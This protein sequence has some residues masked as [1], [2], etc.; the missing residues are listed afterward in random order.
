MIP[1]PGDLLL[2]HRRR[3]ARS[4][5]AGPI[6]ALISWSIQRTTRSR[7]NHVAIADDDRWR[8]GAP[9]DATVPGPIIEAE[10]TGVRRGSMFA[11]GG[12]AHDVRVLP[13]PPS[14]DRDAVVAFARS[15][16][17]AKYDRR[18]ILAMQFAA[19]AWGTRGI[20]RI[21]QARDRAWICSELAAAA[22]RAG[23][24][25]GEAFDPGDF[26]RNP[27]SLAASIHPP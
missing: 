1:R 2:I 15:Q 18:L 5:L 21:V 16:L 11:Y 12:G 13:C 20:R 7:W 25:V 4:L 24:W 22:W 9:S 8:P 23:G 14:V 3:T 19:L 6:G 17:R 27:G 10:W 26:A